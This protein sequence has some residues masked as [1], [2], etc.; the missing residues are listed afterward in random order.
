MKFKNGSSDVNVL[1]INCKFNYVKYLEISCVIGESGRQ[2]YKMV[3]L[4]WIVYL[5]QNVVR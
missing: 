2:F 4:G 1:K 5:F 3:D